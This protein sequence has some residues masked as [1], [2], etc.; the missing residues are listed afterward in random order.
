MAMTPEKTKYFQVRVNGEDLA[1]LRR[2]AEQERISMSDVIRRAVALYVRNPVSFFTTLSQ[3][4][5]A[6]S[7]SR[8]Q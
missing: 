2:Q 4:D 8:P 3:S 6:G 1:V 7:A 5:D